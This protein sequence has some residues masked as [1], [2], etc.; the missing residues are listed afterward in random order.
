MQV[1]VCVTY[2]LPPDIKGLKTI[3]M[4]NIPNLVVRYV[5]GRV[6]KGHMCPASQIAT[7][8]QVNPSVHEG[9]LFMSRTT[10]GNSLG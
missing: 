6:L 8:M 5:N 7:H 4:Y 1:Y 2:L 10:T 3:V 9:S